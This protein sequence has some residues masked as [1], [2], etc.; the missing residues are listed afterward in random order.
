MSILEILGALFL[1]VVFIGVY[2]AWKLYRSATAYKRTEF[3]KAMSVLPELDLGLEPSTRSDWINL[4]QLDFQEEHLR[5]KGADHVGYFSHY[6]DGALLRISL[7]NYKQRAVAALYETEVELTPGQA[8][9]YFD[10]VARIKNGSICV[11]SN[12]SAALDSRP[13]NHSL[14]L[15]RAPCVT[16][17]F[18]TLKSNAPEDTE[19]IKIKDAKEFF[20][21]VYTDTTEWAWR[22]EQLRNDR[23]QQALVALKIK[24]SEELMQQLIELGHSNTVDVYTEKA[25][26]RFARHSSMNLERWELIRDELV[27]VHQKMKLQDLRDAIWDLS[28]QLSDEQEDLLDRLEAEEVTKQSYDALNVFKSLLSKLDIRARRVATMSSPIQSEVYLPRSLKG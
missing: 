26:K 10:L 27:F 3:V 21:D 9:F 12:A 11:S 14:H 17:F 13:S 1:I 19:F 5:N 15:S 23:T 18:R 25:R 6:S 28:D 2:F 8:I 22:E 7:W 20:D 24:P 4:D 16:K